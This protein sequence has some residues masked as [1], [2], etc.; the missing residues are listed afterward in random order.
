[1]LRHNIDIVKKDNLHLNGQ[2]SGYHKA[3]PESWFERKCPDTKTRESSAELA[4]DHCP[5]HLIPQFRTKIGNLDPF[6]PPREDEEKAAVRKALCQLS[7]RSDPG[8]MQQN[9]LRI[10]LSRKGGDI[11]SEFSCMPQVQWGSRRA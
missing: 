7:A 6:S 3:Q 11:C 2:C 9:R 4:S 1:M 8:E 5:H 10:T